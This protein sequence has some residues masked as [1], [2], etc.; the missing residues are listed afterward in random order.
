M[1]TLSS[2]ISTYR[3]LKLGDAKREKRMKQSVVLIITSILNIDDHRI[4]FTTQKRC[5]QIEQVAVTFIVT[6]HITLWSKST[7]LIAISENSARSF[8]KPDIANTKIFVRWRTLMPSSRQKHCICFLCRKL[9]SYISSNLS[10]AL[11]QSLSMTVSNVSM[12]TIG[13]ISSDLSMSL[14]SLN[15]ARIGIGTRKSKNIKKDVLMGKLAFIVMDGKNSNIIQTTSKNR[16]AKQERNVSG[17]KF[18]HFCMETRQIKRNKRQAEKCFF[19][20]SQIFLFSAK[21]LCNIWT[22]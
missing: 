9:F 3:I 20:N 19:R 1:K 6:N 21:R 8:F 17:K 12:R 5:A 4:K 16:H 2:C 18:A 15:Y 13:R 11:F 22:L 7:M 10:F 14:W